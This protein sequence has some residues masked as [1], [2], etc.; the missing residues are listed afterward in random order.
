[1]LPFIWFAAGVFGF[2]S[3]YGWW[4]YFAVGETHGAGAEIGIIPGVIALTVAGV[5][6][7]LWMTTM[8][9]AAS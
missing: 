2:G 8:V 6:G 1:M 9:R 7:W 4:F 5:A 3:L